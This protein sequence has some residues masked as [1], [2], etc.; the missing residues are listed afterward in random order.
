M[1]PTACLA[2]VLFVTP[3]L[4]RPLQETDIELD[5]R[6]AELLSQLQGQWRVKT[7]FA[8]GEEI[9]GQ[10]AQTTARINGKTL[11][12]SSASRWTFVRFDA[13]LNALEMASKIG[14]RFRRQ[15]VTIKD[16][17]LLTAIL[18]DPNNPDQMAGKVINSFEPA[19]NNVIFVWEKKPVEKKSN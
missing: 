4:P 17:K 19:K 9:A 7:V 5:M 8:H 3:D 1:Y 6:A 18:R 10:Q 11:S 2:L 15:L 13:D 14:G 16:G 12:F